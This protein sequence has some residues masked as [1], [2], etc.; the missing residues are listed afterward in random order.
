MNYTW[1]LNADNPHITIFGFDIYA[2]AIIIVCGMIAAFFVISLLFRR[3]NMS[4]DLFLTFFCICLPIAILTT[5]LF[6]CITSNMPIED[7]FSFDSI[8]QGGL[9]IIGGI[10]GG[11]ASVIGVCIVKKVNFFRAGDCIVV[12]LLLAQCIG[13]WGNFANQE[14][15]G[16]VVDNPALQWFPFA[17]FIDADQSWHY[18]FF[19][20]ESMVTGTA[21]VLL[22]LNAWKNPNKPNGVNTACYFITY[23]LIRSI[24]EPLRDPTYILG[25][26]PGNS[27]IPWSFV[28]SLILLA[29]GIGLL[30]YVLLTNKQ[31][32]GKLFGSLYGDP[33][34]ITQFIGDKK[35]EKPKFDKLNLMCKLRPEL[36]EQETNDKAENDEIN[37]KEDN[38]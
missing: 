24:M 35:D 29:A 30:L 8:R 9:S 38:V 1:L 2:Y 31:K 12:G 11:A 36:F 37:E 14:V 18:A 27:G 21:A 17:V 13:R 5:R 28:F 22:F 34:A 10:I 19:F 33:C 26:E 4:A 15:Y 32:E 23:G 16:M 20:Y 7:W 6:Y 25:K 3:R